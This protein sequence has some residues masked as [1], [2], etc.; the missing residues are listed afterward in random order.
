MFL[1]RV[2]LNQ[3]RDYQWHQICA[4][5]SGFNGVVRCYLDAAEILSERNPTRGELRGGQVLYIGNDQYLFTEFNVWNRV[6][7]E[8]DIANNVK[9]C[10][11]GKGNVIQWHQGFEYLKTNNK[12]YNVPSACEAPAQV[13]AAEAVTPP[14]SEGSG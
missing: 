1:C 14:N 6:L 8:Q 3:L 2:N 11:A 5:W 7:S 9:K 12:T 4:T 13:S 10:N